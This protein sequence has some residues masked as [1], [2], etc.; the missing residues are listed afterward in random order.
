MAIHLMN[1]QSGQGD[2]FLLITSVLQILNHIL[3]TL[4]NKFKFMR[5]QRV[6]YTY[7]LL[8][9]IIANLFFY[10]LLGESFQGTRADKI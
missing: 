6:C 4:A 10:D 5:P 7:F 1:W 9:A 8:H 2:S 3:W